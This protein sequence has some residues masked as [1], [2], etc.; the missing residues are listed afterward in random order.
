[1]ARKPDLRKFVNDGSHGNVQHVQFEGLRDIAQ[2][3]SNAGLGKMA[4]P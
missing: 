3:L 4:A 1:M 2:S